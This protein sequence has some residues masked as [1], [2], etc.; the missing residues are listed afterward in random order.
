MMESSH[1]VEILKLVVSHLYTLDVCLVVEQRVISRV[2]SPLTPTTYSRV[3]LQTPLTRRLPRRG[4]PLSSALHH[5]P[6]RFFSEG[7]L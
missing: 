3:I 5:R 6:S 2:R 7:G 4:H 1:P